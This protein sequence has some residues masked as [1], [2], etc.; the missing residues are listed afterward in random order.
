M[1]CV[2]ST[3]NYFSTI[4]KVN[5]SEYEEFKIHVIKINGIFLVSSYSP[6]IVNDRATH[7]N[8]LHN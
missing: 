8:V 1:L 6:I 5:I 2:F 4:L 7:F 3:K